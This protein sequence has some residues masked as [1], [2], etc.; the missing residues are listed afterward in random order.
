MQRQSLYFQS[1]WQLQLALGQ[2]MVQELLTFAEWPVGEGNILVFMFICW[3]LFLIYQDF[4]QHRFILITVFLQ[5]FFKLFVF[6]FQIFQLVFLVF[7]YLFF[8]LFKIIFSI[9]YHFLK[10][11]LVFILFF[12]SYLFIIFFLFYSIAKSL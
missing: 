12:Y 11:F 9:T 2:V 1:C 4:F 6:F 7:Y 10:F 8:Y 3:R 5:F